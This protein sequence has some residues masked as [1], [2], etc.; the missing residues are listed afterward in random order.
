MPIY[1]I[2]CRECKYSGEVIAPSGAHPNCP[3]CGG[4]DT[5]KLM[6]ATSTLT[7]QARKSMPGA[8]DHGCCG[9]KPSQ[10]GCAGPGSCCGKTPAGGGRR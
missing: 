1:E 6:T 4:A 9:S 2:L 8:S 10:A 3:R 7:G 5:E